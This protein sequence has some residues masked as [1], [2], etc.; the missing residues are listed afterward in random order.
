MYESK[1][2]KSP[3]ANTL[4]AQWE[5]TSYTKFFGDAVKSQKK[6]RLFP[7]FNVLRIDN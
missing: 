5:L 6:L 7:E 2:L 3:I 1:T 4:M